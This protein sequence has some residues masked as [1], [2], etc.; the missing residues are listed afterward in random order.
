MW[1]LDGENI[2]MQISKY[3]RQMHRLA[4]GKTE[5]KICAQ[6]RSIALIHINLRSNSAWLRSLALSFKEF[7][8]V[9]ALSATESKFQRQHD[10]LL[11]FALRCAHLRSIALSTTGRKT[12]NECAHFEL[13][14]ACAR[15]RSFAPNQNKMVSVALNRTESN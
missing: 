9:C 6:M 3:L 14:T 5:R 7:A 8:L 1:S 2:P 13:R 15:L 4:Q 12:C 11:K 10:I